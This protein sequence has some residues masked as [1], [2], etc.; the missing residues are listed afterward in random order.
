MTVK[1]KSYIWGV[2]QRLQIVVG[3]A[4][5]DNGPEC[6]GGL[7]TSRRSCGVS[8]EACSRKIDSFR[9]TFQ[10]AFATLLTSL[11]VSS[12]AMAAVPLISP[13]T[14][15][16]QSPVPEIARPEHRQPGNSELVGKSEEDELVVTEPVN[17]GPIEV[18]GRTYKVSIKP[19]DTLHT[20]ARRF[21]TGLKEIKL[22]NPFADTW[23]PDVEKQVTIPAQY[24]LPAALLAS[25]DADSKATNVGTAVAIINVPELRLYLNRDGVVTTYPVSVGRAGWPTPFMDTRVTQKRVNPSWRPTASI[26][27]AAR[28]N[29]ETIAPLYL[30]GPSNPLGKYALRLGNSPYLIHGTNKPSGVGLRASHGCIRMYPEHV[31]VLFGRLSKGDRVVVV[32]EP[33]KVGWSGRELL[34]EVHPPIE[35]SAMDYEQLLEHAF[36]LANAALSEKGEGLLLD[37][38]VVEALAAKMTGMPSV[39]TTIGEATA[40]SLE[41]STEQPAEEFEIPNG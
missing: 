21:H 28:E 14:A 16:I 2:N 10:L 26:I 12:K 39:V 3:K 38:E 5:P 22:A 25:S 1:C 17:K 20:V 4:S 19:E 40:N 8:D 23:L 29:G 7:F 37:A 6:T 41:P 30:P 18:M 13:E 11:A 32:D 36:E 9:G 34:M 33:V 24:V 27:E 35:E 15:L 31:E